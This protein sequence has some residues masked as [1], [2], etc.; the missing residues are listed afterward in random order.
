MHSMYF[1]ISPNCNLS[2]KY[3]FQLE[4]APE[5]AGTDYHKQKGVKADH[6]IV[7]A[8]ARFCLAKNIRHV[9]IFGGEPLY[10]RA[11]FR[12]AVATLCERVPGMTIG[13]I[14]NGTLINDEIMGIFETYPVSILLSLDG[15]KRRHDELRGGFDRIS[16]WFDRLTRLGCVT[17]ATQAGVVSE[18]CDNV[19]YVWSVGFRRVYINIIENSGWYSADDV[20]QFEQEYEGALQAMIRGEGEL[21]CARQA[22]QHLKRTSF[23]QGCGITGE[24]LACDWHGLLYPCHRA[25][26]M[27][28]EFAIGNIYEGINP[29]LDRKIRTMIHD[30]AFGSN[31]SKEFPLV[32][33]CPV[34]IYQEHKNFEG[35][36]SKEFCEM[37][38][39]K[40]KLVAKYYLELA[41]CIERPQRAA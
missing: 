41:G 15:G 38:N 5:L 24:G 40:H 4:T 8:L 19:R 13:V 27:G 22:Y 37:I 7:D 34:R 28:T 26:E 10:Y 21:N 31:S 14:T 16:R 25:M 1:L 12:D 29:D 33:Y 35:E 20:S 32:S 30:R 6:A 17:V 2:C 11:L 18:L 36:W 39:I 23:H 3:C 9:E